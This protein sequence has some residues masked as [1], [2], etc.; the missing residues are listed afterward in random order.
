MDERWS[1]WLFILILAGELLL[2][3]SGAPAND[4]EGSFLRS[5][6]LRLIAPLA[7]LATGTREAF[8]RAGEGLVDRRQLLAEN[9]ELRAEIEKLRL[10]TIRQSSLEAETERLAS[11]IGHVR[12][13]PGELELAT[14]VYLD[15][16]SW[17]RTLILR[18]GEGHL[19]VDQP[20]VSAEGLVGRIIEVAGAYARAQLITDS[21]AG[22]GAVIARNGSQGVVRG[23]GGGDLE[24][25]YVPH[26]V[27]VEVGDRVVT[28]GIDGVYPAG[29]LIG[30]VAEVA[31]GEELFHRI[32]LEPAVDFSRLDHVFL[33]GRQGLPKTLLAAE[34]RAAR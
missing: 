18:G 34:A 17:L 7:E 27:S 15:R 12:T 11:A 9:R 2:L 6:G 5:A 32:R 3:A 20:V 24:L 4:G 28:A 1:G 33:L 23:V 16:S 26:Q 10:T 13:A 19:E 22:V 25:S 31:P 21:A 8:Q 29:L 14:I 30:T